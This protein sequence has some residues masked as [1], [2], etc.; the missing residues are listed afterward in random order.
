MPLIPHCFRIEYLARN[1]QTIF[2]HLVVRSKKAMTLEI[3][4]KTL[5]ANLKKIAD[6]DVPYLYVDKASDG[7]PALLVGEAGKAL[8]GPVAA[9]VRKSAQGVLSGFVS[10]GEEGLAFRVRTGQFSGGTATAL[11]KLIQTEASDVK[12]SKE[13]ISAE[14]RTSNEEE[15]TQALCG[16]AQMMEDAEE[17]NRL[18]DWHKRL[19][20]YDA[21]FK[22]SVE[23][24]KKVIVSLGKTQLKG[25]GELMKRMKEMDTDRKK[26]N[27]EKPDDVAATA[28]EKAAAEVKVQVEMAQEVAENILGLDLDMLANERSKAFKPAVDGWK[29][30]GE[31]INKSPFNID[32]INACVGQLDAIGELVTR[33]NTLRR[34][35]N[36]LETQL[37]NSA[38]DSRNEPLQKFA[39]G[40]VEKIASF[41][42]KVGEQTLKDE[43]LTLLETGIA[44]Q[45]KKLAELKPTVKV[46]KDDAPAYTE[47]G[48]G[49]LTY[50]GNTYISIHEG[51]YG[52]IKPGICPNTEVFNAYEQAL[53]NGVIATFGTGAAG[54][55]KKGSSWEI[56]VRRDRCEAL[57]LGTSARIDGKVTAVPKIG[58]GT[59]KFVLF[60]TFFD[61]H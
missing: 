11:R 4:R 18:R 30:L 42:E 23:A 33:S 15:E 39:L 29:T 52:C 53:V 5:K 48:G 8:P 45:I 60:D 35:V 24:L 57:G 22:A 34:R 36:W 26:L 46:E 21:G 55:K 9:A 12:L 31:L 51:V 27:D 3:A 37:G 44:N 32:A 56:K 38:Y 50:Q 41:R 10:K 47:A 49:K 25:F 59:L 17:E 2:K 19:V 16:A 58:G 13:L 54:V 28:L 40:V 61:A 14:V 43:P 20:T 1:I 6:K 7:K